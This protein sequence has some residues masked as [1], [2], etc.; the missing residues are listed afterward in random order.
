MGALITELDL[1]LLTVV[2]TIIASLLVFLSTLAVRSQTRQQRL[3]ERIVALEKR[4]RLSWIYIKTL[5][6]YCSVHVNTVKNPLP[7]PPAGW[8]GE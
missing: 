4:D 1:T 6:S 2:G 7:E 3:E 5:I 8:A